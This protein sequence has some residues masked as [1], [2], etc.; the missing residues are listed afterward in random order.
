MGALSGAEVV[1]VMGADIPTDRFAKIK[2]DV[3]SSKLMT[4]TGKKLEK[5]TVEY[6]GTSPSKN[7]MFP[8]KIKTAV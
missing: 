8:Q 3:N 6:Y 7:I 5:S 4:N 1:Q 2:Q